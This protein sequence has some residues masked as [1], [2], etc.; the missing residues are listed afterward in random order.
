MKVLFWLSFGLIFYIYAGYPLLVWLVGRLCHR[1]VQ[2]RLYEPSVSIL[3]AARNEESAIAQTIENKLELDYP[4]DKLEIIVVSDGSTDRTDQLAKEF[5]PRGVVVLRQEP[6][7]GKTAALN[8]AAERAKGDLLIFADANSIYDRSALRH[9]AM[10]FADPAVGYVTGTLVYLSSEGSMTARGCGLYMRYENFVRRSETRAGSIV[11]VNGGIDAIR[12]SLYLPM[13]PDDLPDLVLPLS[14]A[15]RG[16]R[17]VYEPA[18]ML[19]EQALGTPADEY[20]MRVRVSLRALWTISEMVALLNV[21]R[22][23]LYALQVLSHKVLRYLA[24]LFIGLLYMSSF[25]LFESGPI[26]RSLFFL[27]TLGLG[28]ALVGYPLAK[29]GSSSGVLT[30]PFYFALVNG[31]ALH[32]LIRFLKRERPRVWTP[33]LG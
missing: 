7:N 22:H 28:A 10:N 9:L 33:R 24:V 3:I 5:V 8:M 32:A 29:N 30:V 23:G 12:R 14:V 26:Y 19:A 1:P 31:A 18:A 11:G 21:R 13:K 4:K 20:R 25:L 27:Q 6:R 15:Q 2:K 17:V 16:H